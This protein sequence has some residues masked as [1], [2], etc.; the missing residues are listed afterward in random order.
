[1]DGRAAHTASG[2]RVV[3]VN[4]VTMST[5]AWEEYLTD[6]RHR[7]SSGQEINNLASPSPAVTLSRN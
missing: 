5:T 7:L 3:Y 1:M 2:A 4:P 6:T